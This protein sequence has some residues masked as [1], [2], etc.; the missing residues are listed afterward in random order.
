MS[1]TGGAAGATDGERASPGDRAAPAAASWFDARPR[2]LLFTLLAMFSFAAAIRLYR[3]EAPG[4]LV[5]RDYTSA[6][7]ARAHYLADRPGVPAWRQ[8]MA[9]TLAAKQ[10]VLEPPVTEWL[11]SLAYRIAGREDMRLGRLLTIAF[12]LGGAVLLLALARRLV[13]TD[14]AVVALGYYLFL[15]L[16]IL[17][18][19]SFQPDALMMLLFIASLLAVVRHHDEQS[20]TNLGIAALLSALTLVY[21]P[22]VMPALVAA[23]VVPRLDR[24]GWRRTLLDRT[25]LTYVTV[26]TIPAFAYYGYGAFVARYF[27]WK[28][29]SSFMVSLY[30]ERA[31][32]QGWFELAVHSLGVTAIVFA[33]F[34]LSLLRPGVP[35][36]VVVGLGLGYVCFGLAF[37][38]HVHT[39][40]YYHAQ[41]IPAVAIAA[42]PAVT[43]LLARVVAARARWR[44]VA[45]VAILLVVAADWALEYRRRLGQQQFESPEIAAAI[46]EQVKHSDRVV[47][48]SPFYGLPLQYLGEFTGAYWPRASTYALYRPAAERPRDLRERLAGLGFEPEFFV[49]TAFGE[50]AAHHEDLRAYLESSC[51]AIA[52]RHEYRIYGRCAAPG[53]G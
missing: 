30:G 29:P 5:D 33:L 42:S 37:T 7:L 2:L 4:M 16:S 18:S 50:Y 31:Y 13:G 22:L 9:S 35:R 25:T 49:I 41:L 36:S 8:E 48:L 26:A 1:E 24:H 23:F 6:M 21:R 38:Y 53:T 34:G 45:A 32:W 47:F 28:L 17:L 40:G 27:H 12:W 19:R 20:P 11:A 15:P 44:R 43:L 46:G 3:L 10:P 52:V 39:H 51:E 14:A